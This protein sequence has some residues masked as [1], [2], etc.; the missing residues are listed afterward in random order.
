MKIGTL[1]MNVAR[2]VRLCVLAASLAVAGL[3]L[4]GTSAQAQDPA[5]G[6]KLEVTATF[7]AP[8]YRTGDTYA[9]RITIRN[10]G[11]AP[12]ERVVGH[13]TRPDFGVTTSGPFSPE[14][15]ISTSGVTIAPGETREA[16][17]RGGL[18]DPAATTVTV[19]ATVGTRPWTAEMNHTFTAPVTTRTGKVSGVAFVD[20]NHNG[21]LDAGEELAA[22][23]VTATNV[24]RFLDSH[25][26]TTDSAGRFTFDALSPVDNR[27]EVGNKSPLVTFH[28]V[29][30]KV[31]ETDANKDIKLIGLVA[32][33]TSK[34]SASMAFTEDTYKP[35]A[36]ANLTVEL[37]NDGDTRVVGIRAFCDSDGPGML[38]PLPASWGPLSPTGEGVAIEAGASQ[39]FQAESVLPASAAEIGRVEALCRFGYGDTDGP[40]AHA[41][42]DV[43]GR[44]G[45]VSVTAYQDANN[46]AKFDDG[47]QVRDLG[48]TLR[49]KTGTVSA[50][51]GADGKAKFTDIPVG[52]YAAGFAGGWTE[53]KDVAT[54]IDV[55][56]DRCAQTCE[57]AIAVKAP[58]TEPSTPPTTTPAPAP[59][60]RGD[61]PDTGANVIGLAVG[62]FAI[63]AAGV[64]A[65]FIARRRREQA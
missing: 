39:K 21:T 48:V 32:P 33:N 57:Y 24:H 18:D 37:R 44:T 10:V 4:G 3:V 38:T 49:G 40:K 31:D 11:D 1:S 27:L 53:A 63:L 35:G 34:F 22:T 14:L 60:A 23:E 62:G 59:Q 20:K 2:S 50:T 52:R 30:V 25:R 7:D 41:T 64:A 55:A 15:S 58:A 45:T 65:L 47:E 54:P 42:A 26:T 13:V 29:T 46:N 51:A 9:A 6:P 43:P 8:S 28:P 16:T 61:L 36:T 5:V 56:A 12:A 17:F 19:T